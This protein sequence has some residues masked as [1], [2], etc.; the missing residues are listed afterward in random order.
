[1]DLTGKRLKPQTEK[2]NRKKVLD[3]AEKNS[4]RKGFWGQ[5]INISLANSTN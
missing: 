2:K 1:M 4:L 5:Q 3:F